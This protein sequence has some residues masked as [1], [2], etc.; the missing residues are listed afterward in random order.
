MNSILIAEVAQGFNFHHPHD[1][2]LIFTGFFKRDVDLV[3][4]LL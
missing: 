4:R 1:L 3:R 2:I